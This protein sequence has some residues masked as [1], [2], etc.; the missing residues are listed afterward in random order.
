[1]AE[2][3]TPEQ[4][5]RIADRAEGIKPDAP[6]SAGGRPPKYKPTFAEQARKLCLLGATDEDLADFF[7]VSVRTVIRW[8]SEHAEFC[9]ALKVAKEEADNRVE[10]SLYQRAVGYSYDSEKVFNY[11]GEVVRA[12]TREHCPPDTTAQIF[13]LKNRKPAEWRDKVEQV[14]SGTVEVT[15]ITRRVVDPKAE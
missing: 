9:Q 13:W 15:Q 14:H 7:E 5:K 10:R 8:K 4:I 1:M 12:A 11:Q 3:L 2:G 6:Q